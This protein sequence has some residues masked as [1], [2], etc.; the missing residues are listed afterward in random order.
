MIGFPVDGGTR[1]DEGFQPNGSYSSACLWT[2]RRT[3]NHPADPRAPLGGKSFVILN[4]I[5]WPAGS[6]L[7][8]QY[9][10]DFRAAAADGTIPGKP[11]PRSFGDEALWWGDGLAVRKGDVS[12]GVSVFLPGA[13]PA[14]PGKLEEQLA[15]HILRHLAQPAS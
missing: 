8:R 1:R 6:G 12:F 14:Q 10:E 11:V 13:M 4:S 7:A 5:Q 2:V 3:G 9:L 15:P